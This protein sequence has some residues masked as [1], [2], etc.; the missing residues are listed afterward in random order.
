[1]ATPG[2]AFTGEPG[3]RAGRRHPG[4]HP[5][6]WSPGVHRPARCAR[7]CMGTYSTPSGAL[8]SIDPTGASALAWVR[9]ASL[10][11]RKLSEPQVVRAALDALCVRLDGSPA[12]ADTLPASGRCSMIFRLCLSS[13]G[14]SPPTRSAWCVAQHPEPHGPQPAYRRQPRPGPGDPGPGRPARPELAASSAACTTRRC[15]PRKP[16]RCAAPTSSSRPADAARSSSP[17]PARAPAAPGPT[18]ARRTSRGASN[19][20]PTAPSASSPSRPSWS[21]APSATSGDHGTA[22]DGGCS[23]APAEACSANRSTAPL[24]TPPET[25]S[26]RNWPPQRSPAAPTTCGTPPCRLWLNA[27]GAP[28]RSPHA[29]GTA[30]TSLKMLYAHCTDGLPRLGLGLTWPGATSGADQHHQ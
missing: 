17:P 21:P 3:S 29:L 10:P 28:A 24:G 19:T 4:A 6:N 11:V 9:R 30:S 20:A 23:A 22:P 13:S 18:P 14:S 26:A 5:V 25:P 8:G 2:T 1:M 16:S 12:A 7:R 15:A 27:S